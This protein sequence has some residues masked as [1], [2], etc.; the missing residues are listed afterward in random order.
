[1]DVGLAAALWGEFEVRVFG[2]IVLQIHHRSFTTDKKK[3]ILVIKHA[4]L[5]RGLQFT[6]CGLIVGRIAAIA[7]FGLT[8][9]VVE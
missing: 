1:M 5:I 6:A 2:K 4:H 8:V 7:A 3:R 9:G